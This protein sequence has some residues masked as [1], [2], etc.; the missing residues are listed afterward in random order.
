MLLAL[1]MLA[2]GDAVEIEI[3]FVAHVQPTMTAEEIAPGVVVAWSEHSPI[4]NGRLERV[5]SVFVAGG[6]SW[7]KPTLLAEACSDRRC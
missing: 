4:Q 6:G 1:L 2:A 5:G 3:D 7:R